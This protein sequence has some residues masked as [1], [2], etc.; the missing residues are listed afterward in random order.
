[1]EA[2][3]VEEAIMEAAAE[4]VVGEETMAGD[5]RLGFLG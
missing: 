1:M 5:K 2:V 4:E 3:A